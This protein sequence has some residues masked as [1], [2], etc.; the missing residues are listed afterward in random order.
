MFKQA[1]RKIVVFGLIALSC[2]YLIIIF[3]CVFTLDT[4]N[5]AG[6]RPT[7]ERIKYF[8]P[9]IPLYYLIFFLFIAFFLVCLWNIKKK[10]AYIG[11]G[12]VSIMIMA[13][14]RYNLPFFPRNMGAWRTVWQNDVV[15]YLFPIAYVGMFISLLLLPALHDAVA[16]F[17][18]GK[19]IFIAFMA[20]EALSIDFVS[21]ISSIVMQMEP[22]YFSM[23]KLFGTMMAVKA[24]ILYCVYKLV[25][26]KEDLQAQ[27][28]ERNR[29]RVILE[30]LVPI[31]VMLIL[32]MMKVEFKGNYIL[33]PRQAEIDGYWYIGS[34]EQFIAQYENPYQD[35]R[36]YLEVGT[37]EEYTEEEMETVGWSYNEEQE[38]LS[39]V[40]YERKLE[41]LY[42][43][44]QFSEEE[45]ESSNLHSFELK[46]RQK[47]DA[48]KRMNGKE[49]RNYRVVL[50]E[51]VYEN[52]VFTYYTEQKVEY[53][54]TYEKLGIGYANEI[55]RDIE[56]YDIL[57]QGKEIPAYFLSMV[58]IYG[59]VKV[60]PYTHFWGENYYERWQQIILVKLQAARQY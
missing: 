18:Y 50:S 26:N 5:H 22:P 45:C 25:L 41:G 55:Q 8:L 47:I 12:L 52:T 30:W 4:D 56:E 49:N 43:M 21:V 6:L 17:R 3:E 27:K 33:I 32:L 11:I 57:V 10:T 31:G 15:E 59:L 46:K 28:D 38:L 29:R 20:F 51:E 14:I 42:Y 1:T 54:P 35:R 39:I 40:T 34:V 58:D 24:G 16:K 9:R 60:E 53:M 44:E 48:G 37:A 13:C 19:R 2:I 23:I 7:P 36:V